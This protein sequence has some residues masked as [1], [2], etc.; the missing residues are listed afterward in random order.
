MGN[1]FEKARRE[2]KAWSNF[3][4]RHGGNKEHG[5][6]CFQR[7]GSNKASTAYI[8]KNRI[9]SLIRQEGVTQ[10]GRHQINIGWA[11]CSDDDVIISMTSLLL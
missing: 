3:L 10:G 11:L 2:L 1:F 8:S 6:L 4:K 9:R 7:H 5:C